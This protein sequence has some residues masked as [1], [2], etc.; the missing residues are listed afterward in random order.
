LKELHP[1]KQP[2]SAGRPKTLAPT[3]KGKK[4]STIVMQEPKSKTSG[5]RGRSKKKIDES[6]S[7]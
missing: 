2:R 5:K 6:K 3:A 4:D 1:K 7:E